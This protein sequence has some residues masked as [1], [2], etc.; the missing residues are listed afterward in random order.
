MPAKTTIANMKLGVRKR[1]VKFEVQYGSFTNFENVSRVGD[2]EYL[3]ARRIAKVFGISQEFLS[4][5]GLLSRVDYI[6]CQNRTKAYLWKQVVAEMYRRG[7]T[8]KVPDHPMAEVNV[9]TLVADTGVDVKNF[10]KQIKLGRITPHRRP[11]ERYLYVYMGEYDKFLRS[12]FLPDSLRW[13]G[14]QPLGSG[15]AAI[16]CG[17]KDTAAFTAALARGV[18][19]VHRIQ[20]VKGA[21]RKITKSDLASWLENCRKTFRRNPLPDALPVKLAAMYMRRSVWQFKKI[22]KHL[23]VV[24]GR[25][26]YYTR[27]SMDRWYMREWCM[28]AYGEHSCYYTPA[29][30]CAKFNRTVGWVNEFIVGKCDVYTTRRY[31]MTQEEFRKNYVGKPD[32]YPFIYGYHKPAVEAIVKASPEMHTI[33]EIDDA[34]EG[35]HRHPHGVRQLTQSKEESIRMKIAA[36]M[37]KTMKRK[38]KDAKEHAPDAPLPIRK[39]SIEL[40]IKASLQRNALERDAKYREERKRAHAAEKEQNELRQILGITPKRER[41]TPKMLLQ[42]SKVPLNVYV[43]HT[44]GYSSGMFTDRMPEKDAYVVRSPELYLPVK[45]NKEQSNSFSLVSN[46]YDKVISFKP[47]VPPAW[48][49]LVGGNTVINDMGFPEKLDAVPPEVAAVGAFGYENFLHNGSW[50]D[51][52]SYGIYSTFPTDLKSSEWVMGKRSVNGSHQVVVLDGPFIAVRGIYGDVLGDLRQFSPLVEGD[53]G[54]R[55]VAAVVSIVLSRMGLK[56]MQIPVDCSM[57]SDQPIKPG[58]LEWNRIE[59]LLIKFYRHT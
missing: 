28:K 46:A 57:C 25:P 1:L 21:R 20:G 12:Y 50:I 6:V 41:V 3:T 37:R 49:V 5:L 52:P 7:F 9:D 29:Q 35:V 43:V 51:G 15:E 18:M 59:D 56:L 40:G 16:F 34:R 36:G 47:A 58:T 8:V 54:Q 45:S 27:E 11:G 2:D 19:P 39:N 32:Q 38:A 26:G 31:V 22:T 24:P 14:S 10:Y 17:Y 23:E 44:L 30:I 42:T 4:E 33:P 53:V 13:I 48:Y 55:M